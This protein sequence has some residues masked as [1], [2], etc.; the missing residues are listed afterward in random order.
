MFST[1]KNK[2]EFFPCVEHHS[3]LNLEMF[4]N[5][6]KNFDKMF[7]TDIDKSSFNQKHRE[8]LILNRQIVSSIKKNGPDNLYKSF[9]DFFE[10]LDSDEVREEYFNIFKE[11]AEKYNFIGNFNDEIMS[12]ELEVSF[13]IASTGYENPYHVDTRKRILHGLMYFK[14]DEFKDGQFAI[15]KV[16][17]NKINLYPQIPHK[18][19][20]IEENIIEPA[21]NFAV[22]ILSTPN[23][24]HKGCKS[25][26]VRRFIYFAY[27]H[28]KNSNWPASFSFKYPLNFEQ[29]KKYQNM[30][31]GMS[32]IYY[33]FILVAKII[34][35]NLKKLKK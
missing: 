20:I 26:G 30:N 35:M 29:G 27:N 24:Y 15:A 2:K 13:A 17:K 12:S 3:F 22:S 8:N 28:K 31:K 6:E 1:I 16:K 11:D 23:S 32:L 14:I 9:L 5:I 18:S 19:E 10:F 33:Y 25:E 21:K 34:Y 4:D 7:N